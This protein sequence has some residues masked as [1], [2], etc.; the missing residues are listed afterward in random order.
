[1]NCYVLADAR[2][3]YNILNMSHK[4]WT[5][6]LDEPS[7]YLSDI[8]SRVNTLTAIKQDDRAQNLALARENIQL[9]DRDGSPMRRSDTL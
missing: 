6:H 7:L 4:E 2:L 5:S 8:D 3:L 9:H 1:M